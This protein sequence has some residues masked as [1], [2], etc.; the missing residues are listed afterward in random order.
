MHEPGVRM[1]IAANFPV[2]RR[3]NSY[4]CHSTEGRPAAFVQPTE[5]AAMNRSIGRAGTLAF[6]LA[7]SA[8]AS[9]QHDHASGAP[10]EPLG[11]VSFAVSCTPQAQKS[12]NRAMALFHSFWFDPARRAFAQVL[13]LDPKCAMAHWGISFMSMGNPLAWPPGPQ[14]L[15]AG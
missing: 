13:E 8:T 3:S 7:C 1:A 6:T 15:Q 2:S 12:S 5:E 14:A 9:A 4:G 11:E 10:P